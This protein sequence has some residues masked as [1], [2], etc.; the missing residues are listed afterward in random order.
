[1]QQDK[2]RIMNHWIA[3]RVLTVLL[4]FGA[5]SAVGGGVLGVFANGAGV[6]LAYLKSTPFDSY[7][8]PGLL[9]GIVVG[10]TQLVAAILLQRRHPYGLLAAAIAGF[11]MVV[12]I[13]VELAVISEYSPLQ[14]LYLAVGVVQLI[15]VLLALGLLAPFLRPLRTSAPE[16]TIRPWVAEEA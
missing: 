16:T 4:W 7:L 2:A 12:W 13:F 11:G 1:M 6:P 9:L 5:A 3:F 15:L 8:L 14:T 10:G